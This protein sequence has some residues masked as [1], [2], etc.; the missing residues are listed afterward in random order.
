[1]DLFFLSISVLSLF[2]SK[3]AL[4]FFLFFSF[5]NDIEKKDDD[6]KYV[7]RQS[8]RIKVPTK[9][10]SKKRIELKLLLN[11]RKTLLPTIIIA[12]IVGYILFFISQHPM[13][14]ATIEGNAFLL[15]TASAICQILNI[16]NGWMKLRLNLS[17][18]LMFQIITLIFG[19]FWLKVLAPMSVVDFDQILLIFV[20][21]YLG[22]VV[23]AIY[24]MLGDAMF[25][26]QG[27]YKFDYNHYFRLAIFLGL[28]IG[29]VV[30]FNFNLQP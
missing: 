13:K 10:E 29:S 28:I 22:S 9:D 26:K 3:F 8:R 12:E 15:L 14:Y 30:Y 1:M 16:A 11:R 21:V 4:F 18:R 2:I 27:V 25:A 17:F 24:S 5:L 6:K 20:V 19:F 23:L 7:S